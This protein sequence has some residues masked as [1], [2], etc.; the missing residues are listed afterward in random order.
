MLFRSLKNAGM[1]I[2]PVRVTVNLSPA[3]I[4]KEGP[5]FDLPIAIGILQSLEMMPQDCTEKLLL[6]GELGLNGQVRPVKG[7]LPIV[8][9]A[10]EKGIVVCLVPEENYGEGRCVEGIRLFGLSELSEAITYLRESEEMRLRREDEK[11]CK[12]EAEHAGNE[13]KESEED[14]SQMNGQESMKRAA[15]IAAAGFHHLLMCGPP[16]SGKSML[17]RRDR[18]SV[19]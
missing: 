7:V 6:I 4:R 15:L 1:K 18:K 11:R 12:W 3:N 8:L 19:V 16:G 9:E 10:K 13:K 14:F 2:P 5:A 17:A